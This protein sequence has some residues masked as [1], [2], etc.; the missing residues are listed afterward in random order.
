MNNPILSR[1]TATEAQLAKL[2]ALL[3]QGS[4]HTHELRRLGI[5]HPAG[6]VRDL[7]GRGFQIDSSRCVTVDSDG[8][9]HRQVARY[10]LLAEPSAASVEAA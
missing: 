7:K 10:S 4:R 6:R 9:T 2:I 3:R 1:S 8:F 5:S